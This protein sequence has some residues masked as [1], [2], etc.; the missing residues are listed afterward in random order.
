LKDGLLLAGR[1]LCAVCAVA[2]Y[3]FRRTFVAFL[4]SF[5]QLYPAG[6]A[7]AASG[8]EAAAAAACRQLLATTGMAE[9]QDYQVGTSAA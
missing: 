2:G 6:K 3:P 5:W 7:A 8:D 4:D 1:A 9:G